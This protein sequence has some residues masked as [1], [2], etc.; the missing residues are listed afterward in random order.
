M[1]R[2]CTTEKSTAQQRQL[3]A[4]FLELLQTAT[5]DDITI[6]QICRNASLS[7]KVFYRLFEKKADVL[8]ALLD[9]TLLDCAQYTPDSSV[10]PGGMH[11]FL[12]FWKEQKPLL[13]ALAQ[14]HSSSLLTERTVLHILNEDSDLQ[15]CFGGEASEHSREAVVFYISGLFALV[16]E[17]HQQGYNKS[18]DEMAQLLMLLMTTPPVKHPLMRNPDNPRTP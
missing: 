3:E 9:H 2:L 1:Y 4:S 14:N 11:R 5:Y 13:D 16:Y 6:S 18:I 10:G 15:Q 17:W 7:R 12:A 8:Y